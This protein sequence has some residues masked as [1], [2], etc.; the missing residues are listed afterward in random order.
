MVPDNDNRLLLPIVR[1]WFTQRGKKVCKVFAHREAYDIVWEHFARGC[2]KIAPYEAFPT[3]I[4]SPLGNDYL[5]IAL[6]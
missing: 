4:G 5:E 6:I 1:Y 2:G 3:R